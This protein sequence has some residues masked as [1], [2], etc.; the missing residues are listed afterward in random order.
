MLRTAFA[1]GNHLED[2]VIHFYETFLAEYDPQRRVDRGVLL[3]A[4]TGYLLYR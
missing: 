1:A 2:P 3:Y 4:A